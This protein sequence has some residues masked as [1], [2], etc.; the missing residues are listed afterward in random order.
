M[1]E[2]FFKKQ[3]VE[4]QLTNPDESE[5]KNVPEELFTSKNDSPTL[6]YHRADISKPPTL[7]ANKDIDLVYEFLETDFAAIGYNDALTSP[8][9]SYRERREREQIVKLTH[10]IDKAKLYYSIKSQKISFHIETR[11]R[12]GLIDIVDELKNELIIIKQYQEQ[13]TQYE[14]EISEKVGVYDIVALS[15]N[16]GFGKGLAAI[17]VSTLLKDRNE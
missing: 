2:N 12:A 16:H 9:D 11:Q 13:L 5:K 10:R 15:Y 4:K 3:S 7:V 17:T 6:E 1:F 8:D 14:K